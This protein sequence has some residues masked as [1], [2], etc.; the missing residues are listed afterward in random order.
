MIHTLND[1]NM[2]IIGM[3][4]RVDFYFDSHAYLQLAHMSGPN[5]YNHQLGCFLGKGEGKDFEGQFLSQQNISPSY[6]LQYFFPANFDF[7]SA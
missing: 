6:K 5:S 2:P 1:G 3:V 7:F 4:Y